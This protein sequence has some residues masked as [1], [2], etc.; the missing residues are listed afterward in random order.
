[1]QKLSEDYANDPEELHIKADNLMCTVLS[2][3]GY[4][5]GVDIFN[6]MEIWYA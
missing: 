1:M 5:E 2:E 3:L 6:R 4:G